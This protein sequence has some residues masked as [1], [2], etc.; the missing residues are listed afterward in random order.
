M[1]AWILRGG[2][3]IAVAILLGVLSGCGHDPN[4]GINTEEARKA[5]DRVHPRPQPGVEMKPG[6]GG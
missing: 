4:R 1:R 6:H 2:V 5:A 3:I